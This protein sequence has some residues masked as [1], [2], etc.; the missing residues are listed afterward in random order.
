MNVNYQGEIVA[1]EVTTGNVRDTQP[2]EE[3]A[4]GLTGKLYGNKGYLSKDLEVNLF[5]KGVALIT[6]VRKHEG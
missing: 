4:K 6:T 3:L 2:V 1:A 5:D